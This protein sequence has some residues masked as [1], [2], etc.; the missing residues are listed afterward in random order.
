M[1]SPVP[2]TNAR[3]LQSPID[4][5]SRDGLFRSSA[6]SW[7]F[8]IENYLDCAQTRGSVVVVVIVDATGTE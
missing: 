2:F 4:P 7:T 3:F 1:L 8:R 6:E 5:Q